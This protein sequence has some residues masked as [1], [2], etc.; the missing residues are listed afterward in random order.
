MWEFIFKFSQVK[1]YSSRRREGHMQPAETQISKLSQV[2]QDLLFSGARKSFAEAAG[3]GRRGWCARVWSP[4][5]PG[6][7][8]VIADQLL[9]YGVLM[10]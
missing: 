10:G 7:S 9:I 2:N 5:P 3:H 4:P 1:A 6:L 8:N